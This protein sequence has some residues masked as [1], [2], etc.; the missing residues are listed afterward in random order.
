MGVEMAKQTVRDVMTKDP[1]TVPPTATL[2]QAAQAMSARDIGD[3]LVVENGTIRSV[4]TDRDIVVRAVAQGRDPT[5]TPVSE[6]AS[7]ASVTVGPDE[8]VEKAVSLMREHKVRRLPVVEQDRVVGI[9]SLGDLA[10]ERDPDSVLA[11]ISE[12]PPNN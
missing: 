3:V 6:A 9:V 11:D 7:M 4:L 2:A 10:A 8:P 5:R 12:A 1:V